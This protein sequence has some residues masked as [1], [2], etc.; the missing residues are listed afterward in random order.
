MR[1]PGVRYLR[2]MGVTQ[3]RAHC[4]AYSCYSNLQVYLRTIIVTRVTEVKLF[5]W[6][7]QGAVE[8]GGAMVDEPIIFVTQHL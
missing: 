1:S 7:V 8:E 2:G 5:L 6:K 3:L 4:P